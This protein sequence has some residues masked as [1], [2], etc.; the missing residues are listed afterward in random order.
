VVDNR[1]DYTFSLKDEFSV[2]SH[3]LQGELREL[4][5]GTAAL[6]ASFKMFQSL[7][8]GI[9][10]AASMQDSI[11]GLRAEL[12][13][14]GK[15]I[16]KVE[17]ELHA[18]N[19]TAM[20]VSS[21]TVFSGE[22]ILDLERALKKGGATLQQIAGEQGAAMAA[23]MIASYEGVSADY[24]G[25]TLIALAS[26][27]GLA[28][29]KF[30]WLADQINRASA[31]SISSFKDI[32][33]GASNASNTLSLLGVKIEDMLT[34]QAMLAQANIMGSEGGTALSAMYLQGTQSKF[35]TEEEL[36]SPLNLINKL[37]KEIE[38]LKPNEAIIK[39]EELGFD[40]RAIRGVAALINQDFSAMKKSMEEAASLTEK[41]EITMSSLNNQLKILKNSA[42][43]NLAMLFQPALPPLAKMVSL[44]NEGS[45]AIGKM[46]S[47]SPALAKSVTALT[48]GSAATLGL[49]GAAKSASVLARAYAPT[50][51]SLA[52]TRNAVGGLVSSVVPG[53]TAQGLGLGRMAGGLLRS[54]GGLMRGVIGGQALQAATGI[55]S[56]FVTNQLDET[57]LAMAASGA[58]AAGGTMGAMGTFGR[59]AGAFARAVP[60]LGVAATAF[61][62]GYNIWKGQMEER[63]EKAK[64][65]GVDYDE[66]MRWV[67]L[68]AERDA[69]AEA[70]WEAHRRQYELAG[71]SKE[72]YVERAGGSRYSKEFKD[73]LYALPKEFR[74]AISISPQNGGYYVDKPEFIEFGKAY[75]EYGKDLFEN[76]LLSTK[77]SELIN[78][79]Q[80]DKEARQY[81]TV[82]MTQESTNDVIKN[83][84]FEIKV[85]AG[86]RARVTTIR[87][88]NIR[89]FSRNV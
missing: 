8:I 1:L 84:E 6:Y 67:E 51:P 46:A 3:K 24:A 47:E 15:D 25:E 16:Y 43:N 18:L 27:F 41:T 9:D 73:A 63:G 13:G 12:V 10:F 48:V 44:L 52:F 54:G 58:N 11:L 2:N 28:A 19:A 75:K 33:D 49:W 82:I 59:A 71:F 64:M 65:K 60:I 35:I 62:V 74:H 77:F 17:R 50:A 30:G 78:I 85:G 29:D 89:S 76:P 34:M 87:G 40:T 69:N 66:H 56:V 80:T 61:S 86:D 26:P 37:K 32:A 53:A 39:I 45:A 72:V 7:K 21:K 70:Y 79:L 36:K 68:N 5:K 20:A 55:Q 42:G 81:L 23:A 38:G 4:A 31:A 88:E 22:A 83:K 14:F 57:R